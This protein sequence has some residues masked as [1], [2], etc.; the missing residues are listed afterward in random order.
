MYQSAVTRVLILKLL[1]AVMAPTIVTASIVAIVVPLHAAAATTTAIPSSR[2]EHVHTLKAAGYREAWIARLIEPHITRFDN[3]KDGPES[4]TRTTYS[5]FL[6]DEIMSGNASASVALALIPLATD[7]SLRFVRRVAWTSSQS[8]D[9]SVGDDYLKNALEYA[10][11][12]GLSDVAAALRARGVRTCALFTAGMEVRDP[13][14]KGARHNDLPF[15]PA[16]LDALGFNLTEDG[17]VD[18][19]AAGGQAER[20]GVAR[21]W[22]LMQI[23]GEYL[24]RLDG[25]TAREKLATHLTAAHRDAVDLSFW[26][27]G[28]MSSNDARK[29]LSLPRPPASSSA[30]GARATDPDGAR[31]RVDWEGAVATLRAAGW[32][33]A[34]IRAVSEEPY[35]WHDNGVGLK[36]RSTRLLDALVGAAADPAVLLAIIALSDNVILRAVHSP[37][38]AQLAW[39]DAAQ[40]SF[41]VRRAVLAR[42]RGVPIELVPDDGAQIRVRKIYTKN[43]LEHALDDARLVEVAAALD[44]RG[45][46]TCE[47]YTP[48]MDI[49]DL[50]YPRPRFMR[51][52]LRR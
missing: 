43:A 19:V 13:V 49:R 30:P 21:G 37:E 50:M 28:L 36:T 31:P 16:R 4:R 51:A 23:D 22:T 11:D 14:T 47:D 5:T 6:I 2:E 27:P 7:E 24:H 35:V 9:M 33:D 42:A 38:S 1:A 34:R 17:A 46:R 52:Q 32:S 3:G 48:G 10:I 8:L 29:P 40:E 12:A 20:M 45:V 15:A 39:S 18:V 44:A 26:E 25:A 41:Q